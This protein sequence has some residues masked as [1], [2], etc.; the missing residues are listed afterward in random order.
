MNGLRFSYENSNS[1]NN[2]NLKSIAHLS[3]TFNYRFSTLTFY[4][5]NLES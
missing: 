2:K 4:S 5:V 3:V 1:T